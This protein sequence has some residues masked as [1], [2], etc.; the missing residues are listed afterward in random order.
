MRKYVLFIM[1]IVCFLGC[2]LTPQ[3]KDMMIK[4]SFPENCTQVD[5][6][7]KSKDGQPQ[8]C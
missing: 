7:V 8:N 2:E 5:A 3:E 4:N 6:D 1:M